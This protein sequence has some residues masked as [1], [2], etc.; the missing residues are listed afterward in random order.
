[1]LYFLSVV[2]AVL[3]GTASTG[4][5]CIASFTQYFLKFYSYFL[6]FGFVSSSISANRPATSLS[7]RALLVVFSLHLQTGKSNLMVMILLQY[8]KNVF[9]REIIDSR[10]NPTVEVDVKT[11]NGLFRAS[12]PSGASTG[13]HEV[14]LKPF[15]ILFYMESH[16]F[17]LG[18]RAS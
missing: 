16:N 8:I 18:L 11:D 17:Y 5:H 13:V 3:L 9:A 14:F 1:M 12:V 2:A 6:G 10:G 15:L 7:V 4:S